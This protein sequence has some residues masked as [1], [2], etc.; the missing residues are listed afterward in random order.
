MR[1]VNAAYE[2]LS[3][4]RK[5]RAHDE[6]IASKIAEMR[7][8]QGHGAAARPSTQK[9]LPNS[10]F[11]SV[12]AH[13]FRNLWTYVVLAMIGFGIWASNQPPSPSGLPEYVAEPSEQLANAEP[14]SP[15]YTR[16]E[17]APNDSVWPDTPSYIKGYPIARAD[18]LSKLTI[19][20]SAN[21]TEVFVKLVALDADRT[22][23]IRHAYIPANSLFTMNKIRAG[24]YDLRHMD[25]SDGSL[26]RSESFNLE[27]IRDVA[28]VR[29]SVMTMTLFKVADGNM[30][31]YQLAPEEF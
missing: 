24:Q 15:S 1:I 28:G 18:G 9:Q 17:K 30:Q 7:S 13:I 27:E 19:D 10:A 16:P 12:V 31:S 29:F 3:D 26:S 21:S 5:R 25:L 22:L 2:V 8:G 6:W 4:P 11:R 23:P 20:N 14:V